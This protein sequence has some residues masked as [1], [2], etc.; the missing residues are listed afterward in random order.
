MSVVRHSL[1]TSGNRSRS[2]KRFFLLN[3]CRAELK[4]RYQE[5]LNFKESLNEAQ[6]QQVRSESL[7]ELSGVI[8]KSI[9]LPIGSGTSA[10]ETI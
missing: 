2:Y 8:V 5:N 9:N 1:Q 4:Y 6:L 3:L 10:G 7:A